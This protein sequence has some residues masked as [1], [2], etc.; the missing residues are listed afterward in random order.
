MTFLK[1]CVI[2]P[3]KQ[4][5][6]TF[7]RWLECVLNFNPFPSDILIAT[8]DEDFPKDPRYKIV[9]SS[10]ELIYIPSSVLGTE[11][12]RQYRISNAREHLRR[13]ILRNTDYQFILSIDCDILVKE[14]Y[15]PVVMFGTMALTG[16]QM[17]YNVVTCKETNYPPFVSLACVAFTRNILELFSFTVFGGWSED[18]S[19]MLQINSS[20]PSLNFKAS[21]GK[22]VKVIHVKDGKEFESEDPDF[23]VYEIKPKS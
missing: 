9:D 20:N 16:S 5:D 7:D 19:F 18:S 17:L 14:P 23:M 22:L 10:G 11:A 4:Y 8:E 15:L 21:F 6:K 1:Y 13:Y 3:V 12:E 2:S